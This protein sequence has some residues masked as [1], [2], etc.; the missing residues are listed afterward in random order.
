ML[1]PDKQAHWGSPGYPL[2]SRC[3]YRSLSCLRS[4]WEE[5]S[6][7]THGE[8]FAVT[9]CSGHKVDEFLVGDLRPAGPMR[10]MAQL[11]KEL[12]AKPHNLSSVPGT[13][14][15]KER[16]NFPNCSLPLHA[17]CSM[18]PFPHNKINKYTL[19]KE[20]HGVLKK[21]LGTEFQVW[22]PGRP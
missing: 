18:R 14:Q 16:T 7:L 8:K 3:A 17:C 12:A 19:K 5:S 6:V 9:S 13:T 15:W 22:K 2:P 21:H 4:C 20:S 1:Q 10:W 11:V